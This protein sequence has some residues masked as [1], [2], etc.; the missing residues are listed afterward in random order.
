MKA[1]PSRRVL[2]IEL[3][4]L[5]LDS[6]GRCTATG[7]NLHA[8]IDDVA[9]QLRESGTD[10]RV[11]RRVIDTAR[12]AREHRLSSSPTIRIDGRDIALESR[13]SSCGDCSALCGCDGGIDCRVWIW[14]GEEY[15][16]AP[17]AMIV[18]ALLKAHDTPPAASGREEQV[19]FA[20]PANL[21]RYFAARE[22][23][24]AGAKTVDSK[25]ADAQCCDLTACCAESQKAAC[26]GEPASEAATRCGC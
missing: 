21:E 6:C 8:A 26:C 20:L 25:R 22:K 15:L 14:Q 12:A 9:S 13:E 16:E 23:H 10:V 3:L 2:Q 11:F 5:D 18:D 17:K 7:R 19:P 4:A 24:L 1:Q